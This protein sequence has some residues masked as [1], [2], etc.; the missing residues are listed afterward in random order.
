MLHSFLINIYDKM[1]SENTTPE[2]NVSQVKVC[3]KKGIYTG[4][5]IWKKAPNFVRGAESD[6]NILSYLYIRYAFPK[7]VFVF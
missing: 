6:L 1:L 5:A 4:K 2:R 3:L 7:K